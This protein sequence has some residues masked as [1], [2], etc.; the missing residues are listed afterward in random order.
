MGKNK[1]QKL[2]FE[3]NPRTYDFSNEFLTNGR[4]LKKYEAESIVNFLNFF[5]SL[6]DKSP[7]K[8]D[9]LYLA[10]FYSDEKS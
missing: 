8:E 9:I 5:N 10:S 7:L 6:K 3:F 1:K 4:K 2:S